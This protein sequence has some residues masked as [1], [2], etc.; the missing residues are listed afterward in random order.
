MRIGLVLAY[1]GVNYG[2]LLQAFATQEVSHMLGYD[3]EIIDYKRTDFKHIR[4]TPYLLWH[5]IEEFG[6]KRKLKTR[7]ANQLQ[8]DEIHK[9]NLSERKAVS[10][11]FICKIK[12]KYPESLIWKIMQKG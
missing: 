1:K 11:V 9:K 2:M 12:K 6:R 10:N 7:N 3:T 4:K 8:Y 5:L